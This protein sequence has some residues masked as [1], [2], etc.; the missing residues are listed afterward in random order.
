M[1]RAA[2]PPLRCPHRAQGRARYREI[3]RIGGNAGRALLVATLIVGVQWAVITWA[4]Y[5]IAK[6]LIVDCRDHS[7]EGDA[8][9][10]R[11][12]ASRNHL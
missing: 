7:A 12:P 3:T 8:R 10:G 2:R 11:Q 6:E 4:P 1:P 9:A 5:P